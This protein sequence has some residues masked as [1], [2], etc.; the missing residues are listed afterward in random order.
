MNPRKYP[1]TSPIAV[2][3]TVPSSVASGAM[4]RMSREPTITRE[5]MSR[6]S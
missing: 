2:P 3:S 1:I 4:M 5:N 6:P